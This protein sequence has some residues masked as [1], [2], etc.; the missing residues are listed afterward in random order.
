MKISRDYM[1]SHIRKRM[2]ENDKL[3]KTNSTQGYRYIV[4]SIR[5]VDA[6][7]KH[8]PYIQGV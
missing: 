4:L 3:D 1:D 5:G 2:R 8:T 6:Y 7:Q